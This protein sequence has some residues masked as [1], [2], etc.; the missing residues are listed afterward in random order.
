MTGSKRVVH[1]T[2]ETWSAADSV[3]CEAG[4]RTYSEHEQKSRRTGELCDKLIKSAYTLSARSV[5]KH[6]KGDE[7]AGLHL[8]SGKPSNAP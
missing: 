5:V 1:L 8:V 6:P 4:R 7:A 3:S 2:N